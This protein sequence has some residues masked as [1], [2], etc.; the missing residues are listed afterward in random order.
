MMFDATINLGTVLQTFA[1]LGSAAY[2]IWSLRARLDILDQKLE[3]TVEKVDKVE[4]KMEKL[5]E[6]V[7]TQA[8]HDERLNNFDVRL[9]EMSNRVFTELKKRVRS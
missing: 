5:S 2:F 1:I 6:V 7:I 4:A 3:M 9:Q 8:K